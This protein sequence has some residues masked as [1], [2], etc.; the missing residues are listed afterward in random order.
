MRYVVN[1]QDLYED[2]EP[3][4]E[5]EFSTAF[6]AVEWASVFWRDMAREHEGEPVA[7]AYAEVADSL[8][9]RAVGIDIGEARPRDDVDGLVVEAGGYK[10]WFSGQDD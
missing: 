6:D 10:M 5:E 3:M 1:G 4:L 7:F 9:I 2:T 8:E